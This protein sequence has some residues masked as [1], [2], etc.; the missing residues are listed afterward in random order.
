MNNKVLMSDANYFTNNS[1]INALMDSSQRV[2]KKAAIKELD[3]IKATL[4]S[5]QIKV[6]SVP[7]PKDCQDGVY[8]AN[9]A[10][11]VGKKAILSRLPNARK[12]EEPY[13]EAVL[14]GLG[15]ETIKMPEAVKAFSG[16]GDAL[17]CGE[18]IFCQYPYRTS[19][20]AHKYL[21]EF[22]P[23][24]KI[25]S[26]KTK[27]QRYFKIGPKKINPITK[28]LD[29]PTYDLDL[30]MAIL[31]TKTANNNYLIAYAPTS[32]IRKSRRVIKSLKNVDKI[33]VKKREASKYLLLNLI[34]TGETVILNKGSKRFIKE[35]HERG[36][37]TI[38]LDLPEL[39][40]GGGSIR[41]S[42]LTLE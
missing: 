3:I 39:K 29:S 17:L 27:P 13:A 34:S 19:K 37:K 38:E 30:A 25:I 32:F 31:K 12:K 2:N 11:I 6:I 15:F 40:K 41:C 1:A 5:A 8:T 28:R 18:Y 36:L 10:F 33:R 16:Q 22:F 9:W 26:L 14:K 7:S 24:K 42:S 21:R 35:L 4:K 20:L 23:E